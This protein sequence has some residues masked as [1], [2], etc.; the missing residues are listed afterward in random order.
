MNIITLRP[1]QTPQQFCIMVDPP[2]SPR[3]AQHY[4]RD[5]LGLQ[6]DDCGVD[7]SQPHQMPATEGDVLEILRFAEQFSNAKSLYCWS[8]SL[9][10]SL[11]VSLGLNCWLDRD[12]NAAI[13]RTL[14]NFIP[15]VPNQ[16]VVDIFDYCLGMDYRL[17]SCLEDYLVTG[18][19][20][21]PDA[22]VLSNPAL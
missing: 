15:T 13:A 5:S 8:P 21:T 19:I 1:Y 12:P 10:V 11:A 9:A 6:F 16:W 4:R 17:S 14:E 22:R 18:I 7:A 3:R 2:G 20:V